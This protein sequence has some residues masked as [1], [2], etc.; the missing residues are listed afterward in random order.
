[1]QNDQ[2]MRIV[3]KLTP[4]TIPMNFFIAMNPKHPY[5][6]IPGKIPGLCF[7]SRC[8]FVDLAHSL[9]YHIKDIMQLFLVALSYLL[10]LLPK[11][12]KGSEKF[13]RSADGR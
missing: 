12:P 7:K 2:M 6:L 5:Q 13:G 8:K 1:M 9:V 11:R 10:S 4:R 3:N